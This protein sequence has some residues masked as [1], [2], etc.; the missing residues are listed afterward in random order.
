MANEIQ[1]SAS[2][3]Y[4]NATAGVPIAKLLA[5]AFNASIV[6]KNYQSATQVIPT[7]V[8]GT[9]I[10]LGA[11]TSLGLFCI[12]NRDSANYL[13]LLNAVSGTAL[14]RLLP[15][16]CVLGRFDPSV[17]AP[18]ALAHTASVLMEY[19]ILEA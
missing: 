9:A 15:G 13:S 19:L 1:V 4:T 11:L 16:E 12:V 6:G 5:A 3:T 14:L 10:N 7:T 18:A 17:T 8:G 2:L